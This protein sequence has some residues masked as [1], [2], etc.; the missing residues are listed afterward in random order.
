MLLHGRRD[1]ELRPDNISHTVR[2]KNRRG[3][4]TLFRCPRYVGH[5]DADDQ[6]DHRAEKSN[7]RVACDGGRGVGGPGAFPDH[8]AAGDDGETAEDE[9][10]E[11]Y[12]RETRG[13][14]AGEE[15]EDEA[16][17][18]E[19]ELEEDGFEGCVPGDIG[20]AEGY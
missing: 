11:T 4:E 9:E 14:V 20:L 8:G 19:G 6:A 2:D 5:A 10:D 7:D 3:H 13:E 17:S 16:D 1:D 15:D 18:A 12:V